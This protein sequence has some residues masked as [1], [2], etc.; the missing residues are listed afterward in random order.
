MATDLSWQD[1]AQASEAIA[2]AGHALLHQFGIGLAFIAT[3]RKDGGP[4]VHPCCP[5]IHDGHLYVF[6]TGASPKRYDLARDGRFA[7]HSFPPEQNDDEFYCSGSARE[8]NDASIRGVLAEQAKHNVR[9]DEVLFELRLN[10]AL[11]TTWVHPRQP[12]T[13]PVHATWRLD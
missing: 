9:D 4:R 5:L 10:R 12:N 8:V 11:H 7:L 2:A 3:T 6:V 1:F 13:Y